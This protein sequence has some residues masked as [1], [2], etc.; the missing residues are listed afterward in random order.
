[1]S[2]IALAIFTCTGRTKLL[3]ET[4]Q[5]FK[6]KCKDFPFSKIYLFADGEIDGKIINHIRPDVVY[7]E[8]KRKGYYN[9]IKKISE[10]INEEYF[11]WLEDDWIFSEEFRINNLI[12][13]IVSNE[14]CFQV[15]LNYRKELSETELLN[16]LGKGLFIS[17]IKFSSNPNITNAL[18]FKNALAYISKNK[19]T[20]QWERA[21]SNYMV[22]HSY[23]SAVADPNIYTFVIHN[24]Y[25][26][27]TDEKFHHIDPNNYYVNKFNYSLL[28][29]VLMLG[30][31][32]F[33][34]FRLSIKQFF[35]YD[36][37]KFSID[38]ISAYKE[39]NKLVNKK[40]D[41]KYL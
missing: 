39:K 21:V 27:R 34:F 19:I 26:V 40:N 6:M 37:Y 33:V 9:N 32:S 22:K 4:F 11:F 25:L 15:R 5:S 28:R 35:K 12:S 10:T 30:K 14:K 38:L 16:P 1:M 2:S 24:G 8:W 3:L 41:K 17:D 31:L 29:R 36:F 23:F 18:L 7:I 13:F 20:D